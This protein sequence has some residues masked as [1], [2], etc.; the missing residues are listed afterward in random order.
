VLGRQVDA[1]EWR[2][3]CARAGVAASA[4]LVDDLLACNLVVASDVGADVAWSFAHGLLCEAIQERARSAGRL[5]EHHRTAALMLQHK[6]PAEDAGERVARHLL[7]AGALRDAVDPLLDAGVR[8]R[9]ATGDFVLADAL[10]AE[11]EMA[12]KQMH[13]APEDPRW[14]E[15]WLLRG[16]LLSR[17]GRAAEAAAW[18]A[19]TERAARVYGWHVLHVR[20]LILL[21][22]TARDRD[23][24]V[25]AERRLLRAE[26]EARALGD[27]L[28]L[29]ECLRELG[30]LSCDMGSFDRGAGHWHEALALCRQSGDPRGESDAQLALARIACARGN[31]ENA[32]ETAR[33]ARGA[34]HQ[35][36]DRYGVG[37]ALMIMGDAARRGGDADTAAGYY[38][39][40]LKRLESLGSSDAVAV[41][42]LRIALLELERGE[43]QDPPPLLERAMR[44]LESL[45][46]KQA[47]AWAELVLASYA[48]SR[49]DFDAWSR[50]V[51]QAQHLLTGSAFVEADVAQAAEL[52]GDRAWSANERTRSRDAYAIAWNQWRALGDE[53]A[54]ARLFAKLQA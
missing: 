37:R 28:L 27:R 10:L 31:H 51:A 5:H 46:R 15:G 3:A 29:G 11:R 21:G 18:A 36:G 43:R 8:T 14:G 1:G 35:L 6:N 39:R 42:Q 38:A 53:P 26:G 24:A 50:H 22:S 48:A 40:A 54:V 12:M 13:C 23:D 49:R 17:R 19:R 4:D 41:C 34:F 20:A 45:G 2:E 52:A 16:R 44:T 33:Q 47:L 32:L 25:A 30:R 9:I 7:A